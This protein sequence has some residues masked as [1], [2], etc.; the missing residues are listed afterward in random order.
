MLFGVAVCLSAAQSPEPPLSNTRLSIEALVREDVFAGILNEDMDRLA[1]GERSI[2]ILLTQR[3]NDKP[4]LL[5][6]KAGTVLYRAVRALEADRKEEFEAKYKQAMDLLA[7]ARTLG[8]KDLGVTAATAGIYALMA[9]RLP[10]RLRG[11]A[12]STA[13]DCYQ[14]LWTQQARS[15]QSLPLHLRGELL[16]GLA[17]SAQ[18]TGRT[19]EL[20]EY[21]DKIL[22]VA[23]DTAYARVAQQW[24][25]DPSAATSTRMTCLTCHAPGR[26][27]AR[28][29]ALRADGED[30]LA[31]TAKEYQNELKKFAGS[32]QMISSE[33]D[34]TKTT[35]DQVEQT[36]MIITG[37][38]YTIQRAGIIIEEGWIDIDPA[39]KPKAIDIYPTKPE[40]K[41]QMGIYE[42]EG[43]DQIRGC[44]TH[45]GTEQIRPTQFSTTKGSGHVF[46]VW[47]RERTK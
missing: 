46:S 30:N 3:P 37:D 20:G 7:E 40:G 1:R 38:K 45:P 33:K 21:L 10:Q 4:G 27:A 43:D 17:Q 14:A 47:K 44:A 22:A 8:P 29:A 28:K 42:W 31:G 16:G 35:K 41:V 36:K 32:W 13:Y 26:L 19:K 24:K 12:W 18:R 23:P 5:A 15:L 2:D 6:W 34:G 11:S 25:A 39:K 9:D